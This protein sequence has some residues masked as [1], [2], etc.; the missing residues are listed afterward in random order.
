MFFDDDE[1]FLG[2]KI[3]F[4]LLDEDILG[5]NF[6]ITGLFSFS[7]WITTLYQGESRHKENFAPRRYSPERMF[8]TKKILVINN[9]RL[10]TF[11]AHFIFYC[12]R[13]EPRHKF[14][15]DENFLGIKFLL[16]R[17]FLGGILTQICVLFMK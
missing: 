6:F 13:E 11:P 1:D 3:L 4:L 2:I 14:F 17:K 7:R 9:I 10:V 8:Y 5:T 16:P 15:V 12:R